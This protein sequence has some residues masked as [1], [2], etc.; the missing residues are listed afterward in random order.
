MSTFSIIEAVEE[1]N[2]TE[3]SKTKYFIPKEEKCSPN[4]CPKLNVESAIH[5]P[6]VMDMYVLYTEKLLQKRKTTAQD[7]ESKLAGW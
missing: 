3:S 1:Q 7:S 5:I 4:V 2:D 6:G